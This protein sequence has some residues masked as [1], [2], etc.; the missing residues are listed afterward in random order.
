MKIDL[1]ELLTIADSLENYKKA[2]QVYEKALDMACK[3]LDDHGVCDIPFGECKAEAGY[4]CNECAKR[5]FL[6]EAREAND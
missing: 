2:L 1:N 3:S 6:N 4:Y 5:Y